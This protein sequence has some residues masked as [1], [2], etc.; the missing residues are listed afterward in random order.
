MG[1]KVD[2]SKRYLEVIYYDLV[3]DD[4]ILE[5]LESSFA[6]PGFSSKDQ[7]VDYTAVTDYQVSMPGLI[8]L[9]NA[10][11]QHF[12]THPPE[13]GRKIG[14]VVPKDVAWGMGRA[15]L[16]HIEAA[17]NSKLFRTRAE[18]L[19]WMGIDDTDELPSVC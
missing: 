2:D 19:V 13:E 7:L 3:D 8:R 16:A 10:I 14:Y 12:E 15:F 4:L 6:Q 11:K 9:T 1:F 18:A 17:D 5:C